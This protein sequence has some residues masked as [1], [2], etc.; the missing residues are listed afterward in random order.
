MSVVPFLEKG[1]LLNLGEHVRS[2]DWSP[3]GTQAVVGLAD[4]RLCF[5]DAA[6]GSILRELVAHERGINRWR[7]PKMAKSS[8]R[9]AKMAASDA[10]TQRMD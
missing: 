9:A 2:L 1:W 5:V 6:T 8:L 4:G 10:G 3:D 7:G